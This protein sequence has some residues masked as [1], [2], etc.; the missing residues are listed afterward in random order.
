MHVDHRQ[1][2]TAGDQQC[3]RL[4]LVVVE[5]ELRHVTG[6]RG[7]QLVAL[8]AGQLTFGDDTVEEDLDVDFV[9]AAVDARRVVDG[10]RVD[11]ATA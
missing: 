5:H 1:R 10:V 7:Q 9:V 11:E 8:L 6:H 3:Q 2:L 4:R